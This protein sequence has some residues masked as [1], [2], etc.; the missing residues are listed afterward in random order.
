[1]FIETV[2]NRN[3]PP[4]VLLRESYREGGKVKHRTLANLT[5]WPPEVVEGLREVL[6][7]NREGQ[8][9]LG[10][11]FRITRSLP[12]GHVHAVLCAIRQLRLEGILFSRRTSVRN[13]VVAMIVARII[14]PDSKLA[15]ARSLARESAASTLAEECALEGPIHENKLYEAMDWL[16]KA[17]PRIEKKLA[18]RHLREGSLVLYDLSSSYFEGTT[19]PLA[20]FGYN[21]DGKKGKLQVTYGL[22][23]NE[24]GCPVAVEVFSGNTADP[25]TLAS[26]VAKLRERFGLKRVVLVGDRGMITQARIDQELREVEGLQWISALPS[27]QIAKLAQAELIQ[28]ELFDERNL[29]EVTSPQF[30]GERLIVCRNRHLAHHRANKRNE[31]LKA[32]EAELEKVRAATQRQRQPL[33]GQD[34]I[35]LRVGKHIGKYKMAKHFTLEITETSLNWKRNQHSIEREAAIDGIYV[36]RTSVNDATLSSEQVVAR[37]KDLSR[38]EQAFRSLKTVDLKVRP[39]H[40]RT[41]DRVRSHIFLCMLAYHVEWHMRQALKPLLFDED[42]PKAA[43]AQRKDPVEAKRPS[44]SA[45]RKAATKQTLQSD[46]VHSFRTLLSDLATQCRNTITLDAAGKRQISRLTEPTPLQ[47]QVFQRIAQIDFPRPVASS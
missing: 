40:H 6:R 41:A 34:K 35:A 39:I 7:K 21:R 28:P 17:Q 15:T 4:T 44:P 37:Y 18:Q 32:T 33:R 12:H 25:K 29:A 20:E 24:E 30:P 11:Q 47:T 1:M 26:Q 10:D 38:V 9:V 31:L 3:S 8:T 42:D 13:L 22:L 27:A 36:V 45:R 43:A 14:A 23:C 2:R 46:P 19:C 5:K 16:L